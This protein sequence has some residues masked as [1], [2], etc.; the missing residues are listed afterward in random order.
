MQHQFELLWVA[1]F[2]LLTLLGCAGLVYIVIT[3]SGA[4]D[5]F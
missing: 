4:N 3:I 5:H 1:F 2:V